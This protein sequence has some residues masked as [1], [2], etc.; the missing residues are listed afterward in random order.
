MNPYL[1]VGRKER[2]LEEKRKIDLIVIMT[3]GRFNQKEVFDTVATHKFH[4]YSLV[5]EYDGYE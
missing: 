1:I 5:L 2:D 3:G 4:R